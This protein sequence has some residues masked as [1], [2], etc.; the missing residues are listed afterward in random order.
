MHCLSNKIS[1]YD[2]LWSVY[3]LLLRLSSIVDLEQ[4]DQILF[5]W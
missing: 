4:E 3:E 1:V 5:R 2:V